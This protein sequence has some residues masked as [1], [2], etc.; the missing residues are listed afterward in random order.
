MVGTMKKIVLDTDFIIKCLEWKINV[1]EELRKICDFNF[2]VCILDR[3]LDELKGKKAEQLALEFIKE[4]KIIKTKRDKS[5]DELVMNLKDVVVAT[6]DKE[7]KEK[8]KKGGFQVITIRQRKY[9][10]QDVL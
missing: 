2:E 9:L 7:L 1:K 10:I 4:L 3:T 5:V 8:L 6:Q